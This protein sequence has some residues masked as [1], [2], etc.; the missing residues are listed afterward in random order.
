MQKFALVAEISTKVAGGGY[1]LCS[2]S[3]FKLWDPLYISG[4]AKATNFKFGVQNDL[5]STTK[6]AKSGDKMAVA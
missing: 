3:T 1:F 2:P 4:M 6:N 5:M